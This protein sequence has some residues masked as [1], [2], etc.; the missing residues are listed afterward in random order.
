MMTILETIQ[1][2]LAL[3]TA[4]QIEQAALRLRPPEEGEVVYCL[5][6]SGHAKALWALADDYDRQDA[7]AT[8]AS[9]FDAKTTS[10]RDSLKGAATRASNLESIVRSLA[11]AE[12]MQEADLLDWDTHLSLRANYTLVKSAPEA[13]ISISALPIPMDLLQQLIQR[14]RGGGEGEPPKGKPQ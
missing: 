11:W 12:M 14:R 2:A 6:H 1:A 10:E 13:Q 4:E 5:I 8:H 7:L 9:R 3:I